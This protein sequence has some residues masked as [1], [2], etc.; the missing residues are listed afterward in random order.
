MKTVAVIS[1]KG[2]V[3][4]TT[5]ALA[6]SQGFALRGR[7]VMAVDL[8]PQ[9]NL[10]YALGADGAKG[11]GI[12]DVLKGGWDDS[13]LKRTASGVEA[14]TS[15]PMLSALA[16]ASPTALRDALADAPGRLS[17][18]VIDTP[19]SLDAP[20]ILGLAAAD[21]AL[22]AAQCDVFSLQSLYQLGNT[23]KVVRADVNPSLKAVGLLFTRC[24]P[25]RPLPASVA[26]AIERAAYD[27]FGCG[28]LAARIRESAALRS[29][30]TAQVPIYQYMKRS[31]GAKDYMSLCDELEEMIFQE[32]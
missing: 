21:Y 11:R 31:Y 13:A 17:L 2:G 25:S 29:A 14:V 15:S 27:C 18:C 32:D 4:K 1:Q 24:M 19:P 5:T 8:D 10:T 20:M 22:I 30:E 26:A 28:V 9:G 16:G 7:T 12:F 3:G 6:L 23:F